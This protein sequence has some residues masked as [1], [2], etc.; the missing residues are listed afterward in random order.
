MAEFD[1]MVHHRGKD[2]RIVNVTPYQY[3]CDRDIGQYYVRDGKKFHPN[4]AEM[5]DKAAPVI[6]DIA[7]EKP[8]KLG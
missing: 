6:T 3:V 1:L 7:P 8:K 2:G 5:K 4:G